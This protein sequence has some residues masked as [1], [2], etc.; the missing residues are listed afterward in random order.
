MS[1]ERAAERSL[2]GAALLEPKRFE[3]VRVWLTNEDLQGTA[4]RQAFAAIASLQD[5]REEVT[6]QAVEAHV[7]S[8]APQGT[9]L[10]DGA[11]LIS[12]M[13]ETPATDRAAVYGRM[14]LELSIRR[15]VGEG[16]LRLRQGAESASSSDELN[17][18]FAD[19]DGI[20]RGIEA[21][22]RRESQAAESHSVAPAT[23]EGMR[24]LIRFPRHE[25]LAAE[26]AAVLTL[27]ERP[28][29]IGRVG[30]WL[31]PNDFGDDECGALFNE[32][33]SL[34]ESHGPID[35]LTVAWRAAQV[36]I[37]GPVTNA[38][39]SGRN[40]VIPTADPVASGRSVLEQSVKAAMIAT[41]QELETVAID[42]SLNPTTVAYTRLNALWP[43]Q[44][45]LVKARLSSVYRGRDLSS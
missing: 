14:V 37:E 7:R 17:R 32:L 23:D 29:D 40:D 19:V 44:R 2:I 1:L 24:Q 6:P 36:G 25:E 34:H 22:H 28:A 9:Q 8:S 38:L 30:K 42:P 16:A 5:A 33:V 45:R 41:S 31:K 43:Q 4:E 27:V 35:R 20:R 18:V 15:R 26:Q 3:A 10:A 13:Q 12:V 39:T 21:L 11:Y